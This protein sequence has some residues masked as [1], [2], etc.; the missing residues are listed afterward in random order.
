MTHN[1]LWFFYYKFCIS[2]H[3]LQNCVEKHCISC[4]IVLNLQGKQSLGVVFLFLLYLCTG[5]IKMGLL[6]TFGNRLIMSGC[7]LLAVFMLCSTD[8]YA[9]SD[10]DNKAP[11]GTTGKIQAPYVNKTSAR[12][13]RVT[14]SSHNATWTHWREFQPSLAPSYDL[15]S[16][17]GAS[18][19][20]GNMYYR[21]GINII[22]REKSGQLQISCN[23]RNARNLNTHKATHFTQG[24]DGGGYNL[25]CVL[26]AAN[27]AKL[28]TMT[29]KEI[30][31]FTAP[32]NV[33]IKY[34]NGS[35]KG[36]YYFFGLWVLILGKTL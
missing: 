14:Y 13:G 8:T 29:M 7:M 30:K 10:N 20:D 19:D 17:P 26:E 18:C 6:K 1:P 36:S 32:Y 24:Y 27:M 28:S 25:N 2:L 15:Y 31:K 34:R 9:D 3:I 5:G 21:A 16:T 12:G 11:A 4:H 33:Y 23:L 22:E 35:D